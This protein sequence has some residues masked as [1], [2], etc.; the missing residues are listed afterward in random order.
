MIIS[1]ALLAL[2]TSGCA[3]AAPGIPDREPDVTGVVALASPSGDPV[4]A[5]PSDAYFEGMS[6]L[7]GDPV[8]VKGDDGEA[9]PPTELENGDEV[10][11]WIDGACAE[12]YPVQ[13]GIVALR[14]LE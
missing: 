12:S 13:C 2:A 11:V 5:D 3:V 10:E 1:V 4:L 14:L 7:Q 9:V 6:L 8:I